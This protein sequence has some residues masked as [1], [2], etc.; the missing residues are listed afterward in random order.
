MNLFEKYNTPVLEV[1]FDTT[2]TNNKI[3]VILNPNLKKLSF[4]KLI[5]GNIAYQ[6][7]EMFLGNELLPK[8]DAAQ[9]TDSLVLAGNHG[10]NKASFR[11]APSKAEKR[12]KRRTHKLQ[13]R[14]I[15]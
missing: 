5:E 2:N 9:I 7:L 12:N 11:K 4:Y 13:K 14:R 8:D 10:F 15:K 3:K 6:E 1:Q